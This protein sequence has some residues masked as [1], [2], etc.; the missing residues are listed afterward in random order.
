MTP[1][2]DPGM[3]EYTF[4]E[5]CRTVYFQMGMDLTEKR[6]RAKFTANVNNEIS[7]IIKV[8]PLFLKNIVMKLVFN[9]VG[10]RKSTLTLSNLG[11]VDLPDEM[12]PYIMRFD[13]IL[14]PQS[15][16]PYNCSAISYNG[17][18]VFNFIRNTKEPELEAAFHRVLKGMGITAKVESNLQTRYQHTLNKERN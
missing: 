15:T 18:L 4:E 14:S 12:K 2:V 16:A 7:P 3:G 9:A 8:M 13:F 1:Y 11:A 10:E 17:T 5:I 6:M